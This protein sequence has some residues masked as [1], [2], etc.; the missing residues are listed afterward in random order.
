MT[1][2]DRNIHIERVARRDSSC[3][4][5][6]NLVQEVG[7][8]ENL[9]T[10][11]GIMVYATR[12]FFTPLC[13]ARRDDVVLFYLYFLIRGLSSRGTCA[14]CDN[15]AALPNARLFLFWP[16]DRKNLIV[17]ETTIA[18]NIYSVIHKH[19]R[20]SALNC[21]ESHRS[22]NLRRSMLISLIDQ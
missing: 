6:G 1:Q 12:L 17:G 21:H 16:Q 5:Y 18:Y 20:T 9:Q 15:R 7:H 8:T 22:H 4:C 11:L 2:D 14:V 3:K 10:E 19:S 13:L